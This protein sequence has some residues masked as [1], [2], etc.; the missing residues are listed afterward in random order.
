MDGR[1]INVR[2]FVALD[3]LL[4]G[5]LFILSEFGLTMMLLFGLGFQQI[6]SALFGG[7]TAGLAPGLYLVLTGINFMV[8]LIYAIIISKKNSAESE[9]RTELQH[10]SKYIHQQFL[11][12][13]PLVV[14]LI[15]VWQE[16]KAS[17]FSL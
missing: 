12:L 4:H 17:D 1:L 3:M 16:L 15:A 10:K 5:K 9:A 7:F 13:I 14:F 8:L 2:M 6:V 11:L